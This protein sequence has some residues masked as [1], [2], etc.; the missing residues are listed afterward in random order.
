MRKIQPIVRY[1]NGVRVEIYPLIEPTV[2]Q[3]QQA[4]G[5]HQRA[6]L[7]AKKHG[8]VGREFT[9]MKSRHDWR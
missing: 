7:E 5:G 4:F 8:L 1:E 9:A 6:I 3:R 2:H